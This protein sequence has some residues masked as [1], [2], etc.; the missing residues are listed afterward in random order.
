MLNH[1]C[2]DMRVRD[3]DE[4][5]EINLHCITSNRVTAHEI[6]LVLKAALKDYMGESCETILDKLPDTKK[7]KPN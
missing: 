6:A 1:V 7:G 2:M 3:D 4:Q 5:V